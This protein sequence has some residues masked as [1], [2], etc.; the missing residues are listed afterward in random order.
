MSGENE[1]KDKNVDICYQ[2]NKDT[3]AMLERIDARHYAE[4]G[5]MKK[6][7]KYMVDKMINRLPPW[8]AVVFS[9]MSLLIG[10]LM[11]GIFKLVH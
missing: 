1:D 7:M 3:R 6:D 9:F 8:V 11:A 2:Y 5:E 4:L 10:A